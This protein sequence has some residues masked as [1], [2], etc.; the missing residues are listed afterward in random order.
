MEQQRAATR[1]T[2]AAPAQSAGGAA[3]PAAGRPE[4]DESVD[5]DEARVAELDKDPT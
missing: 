5:H 3:G 1:E 2:G 4:G